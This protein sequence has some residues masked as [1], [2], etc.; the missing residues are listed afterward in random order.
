MWH[1]KGFTWVWVFVLM[2]QLLFGGASAQAQGAA[3]L[4]VNPATASAQVGETVTVSIL[5]ENISNLAAMELHLSFNQAVLEVLEIQ[6]GGFLTADFTVQNTF[7]NAAGT[8]DYA[9]AQLNRAS[10]QGSGTALIITFRAKAAGFSSI[11][12]RPVAAAPTGMILASA[13][14][15]AISASWQPGAV[16]VGS[17]GAAATSTPAP[18]QAAATSTL[19]PTQA[20]T[21]S[22]PASTQA[23]ATA[24]PAP[25]QATVTAT[26]APVVLPAG[27]IIGTHTVQW[28][29]YL[30][31]IGR[32]YGVDAMQIASVNG[33]WWPYIIFPGQKLSIPYAP[34]AQ[35]PGKVCVAQFGV[36]AVTPTPL[37][38]SPSAS[39]AFSAVSPNPAAIGAEVYFDLN[40]SVANQNPGISGAEFFLG[41]NPALVSPRA[42]P[43]SAAQVKTD[44]FTT[45]NVSVNEVLPAAQCP[46]GASPCIHLVLAGTP[47]NTKNASVARFYFSG[48]ANG[49]ASFAMLQS[50]LV[51]ANGQPVSHTSASPTTV[52]I[53]PL[54]PTP[55][56]STS[57]RYYHVVKSGDTLYRIGVTYGVS[58]TTIA[59]ANNIWYPWVI[60]V[61]QTLCIP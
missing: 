43:N 17:G 30:Y 15:S 25:T 10:A 57:C 50:S 24:T 45:L 14:G 47:I 5:A 44:F 59:T 28:G 35:S 60:Y 51:N 41:Y 19:V 3:L 31:C 29:E 61:G 58:Y 53:S 21:T 33:V 16:T 52:K 39:V 55:S 11:A 18:T 8:V 49:D 42:A 2:F 37:P 36:P 56:A 23:V 20:A 54:T 1:Q 12:L 26:P 27:S 13:D 7:D 4:R 22:T 34:A 32:A 9:I 38:S 6:N 48:I 40:L 46:G